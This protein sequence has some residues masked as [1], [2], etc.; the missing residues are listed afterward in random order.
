[1]IIT[2]TIKEMIMIITPKKK[3]IIIITEIIAMMINTYLLKGQ[4]V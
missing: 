2:V 3:I 4:K 1:M